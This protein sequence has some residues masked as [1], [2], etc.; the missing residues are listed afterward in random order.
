MNTRN[1]LDQLYTAF[2]EALPADRAR[3]LAGI[4]CLL[5]KPNTPPTGQT[6]Y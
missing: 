5:L 6:V 2:S 1:K 3:L 4:A